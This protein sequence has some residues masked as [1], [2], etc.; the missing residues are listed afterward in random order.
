MERTSVL[1]HGT[2]ITRPRNRQTIRRPKGGPQIHRHIRIPMNIE[3]LTSDTIDDWLE[4]SSDFRIVEYY[5][6]WCI[7]HLLTRRKLEQLG[8]ALESMNLPVRLGAIDSLGNESAFERLGIQRVPTIC[9]YTSLQRIMWVGDTDLDLMLEQ[10]HQTTL[11]T[12]K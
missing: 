8:R 9:C 3:S 5:A 10:V 7:Y 6:S 11:S 12:S 2:Q 4:S 1:T